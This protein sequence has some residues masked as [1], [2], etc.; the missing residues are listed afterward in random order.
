LYAFT[1]QSPEGSKIKSVDSRHEGLI[2]IEMADGL[3]FVHV[4]VYNGN[5]KQ[6]NSCWQGDSIIKEKDTTYL[7]KSSRVLLLEIDKRVNPGFFKKE[8]VSTG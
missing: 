6:E 5:L 7:G 4:V 3:Y 8:A 2:I 1:D